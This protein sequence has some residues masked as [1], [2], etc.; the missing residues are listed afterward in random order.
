MGEGITAT[1]EPGGRLAPANADC[2]ASPLTRPTQ[3]CWLSTWCSRAP[4]PPRPRRAGRNLSPIRL[5]LW[6]N[7]RSLRSLGAGRN[8]SPIRLRLWGTAARFASLGLWGTATPPCLLVGR[9]LPGRW[10]GHVAVPVAASLA[11]L[12][13]EQDIAIG[14]LITGRVGHVGP[15]VEIVYGKATAP[16]IE[17]AAGPC[18]VGNTVVQGV[19][20]PLPEISTFGRGRLHKQEQ[21]GSGEDWRHRMDTRRPRLSDRRQIGRCCGQSG[22][23]EPCQLRLEFGELTPADHLH[24]S[25]QGPALPV[26]CRCKPQDVRR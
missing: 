8:L 6:G 2:S 7:S 13:F 9:P 4:L 3:S 18:I 10:Q 12:E 22:C 26:S 19:P 5:R 20:S 24:M 16:D 17:L 23:P 15:N 14:G 25:L 21:P 11:Q 1:K